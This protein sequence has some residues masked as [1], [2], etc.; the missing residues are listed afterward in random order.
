ME[1]TND[2]LQHQLLRYMDILIQFLLTDEIK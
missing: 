1:T 2:K